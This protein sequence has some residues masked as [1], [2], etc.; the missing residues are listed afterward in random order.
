MIALSLFM[1]FFRVPHNRAELVKLEQ[2]Q[3]PPAQCSQQ[4]HLLEAGIG[5]NLSTF[6]EMFKLLICSW[7]RQQS[8][9]FTEAGNFQQRENIS[10][11]VWDFN[12]WAQNN[13]SH[14]NNFAWI[15][16]L[17]S[18]EFLPDACCL[19]MMQSVFVISTVRSYRKYT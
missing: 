13:S 3:Q 10:F 6:V 15:F 14:L 5:E 12:V 18:I 4:F 16:F 19:M 1:Q 11:K 8:D 7:S 2:F 17:F 9:D